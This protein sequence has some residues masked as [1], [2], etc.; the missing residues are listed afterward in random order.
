LNE[1]TCIS[2]ESEM[3]VDKDKAA[4]VLDKTE[5]LKSRERKSLITMIIVAGAFIVCWLPWNLVSFYDAFFNPSGSKISLYIYVIS[6]MI[7]QMN[8]LMNPIIYT[9]RVPEFQKALVKFRF[10]CISRI[11]QCRGRA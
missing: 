6:I 5:I 4:K 10:K 1:S 8:S 11:N 2:G 9:A 3:T 7:G